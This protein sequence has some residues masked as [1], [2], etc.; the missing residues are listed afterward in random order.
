MKRK[1]V[2]HRWTECDSL[3]SV[4]RILLWEG[5]EFM[6]QIAIRLSE[7]EKEMLAASAAANDLTIS[8]ILRSL[9]RNYLGGLNNG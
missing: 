3:S 6:A 9:I 7:Q 8:Q 1:N 5:D 4:F 2:K